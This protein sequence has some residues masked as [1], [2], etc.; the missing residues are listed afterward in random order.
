MNAR[1]TLAIAAATILAATTQVK[2]DS[3][4]ARAEGRVRPV[5]SDDTARRVGDNITIV[6][7]EQTKIEN[8]TNRKMEKTSSRKAEMSGTADTGDLISRWVGKVFNLPSV[9]V[10]GA[11]ETKFDGKADFDASRSLTDQITVTVEDVLPNGNLVVLGKREREVAGDKQVI[12]CSGIVRTSDITF[13][14]TVASDKVANFH[15]TVRTKGQEN[16]F[17]NPGWLA[18]I[19]NFLNPN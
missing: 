10:S 5:T 12:R 3:I 1:T 9:D 18:R 2:A 16:R 14:N 11:G 6:I 4:W 8:E 15:I 19:L 17:H 7:K 13:D